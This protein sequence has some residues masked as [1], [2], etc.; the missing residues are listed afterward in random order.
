LRQWPVTYLQAKNDLVVLTLAG[1]VAYASVTD[2][3]EAV[4]ISDGRRAGQ[5]V[6]SRDQRRALI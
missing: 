3:A 1:F 4:L 2:L 6:S 5:A